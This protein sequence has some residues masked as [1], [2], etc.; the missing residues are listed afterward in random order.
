MDKLMP[1]IRPVIFAVFGT[2][3]L[4]QDI[5]G[6]IPAY[7]VFIGCIIY[8]VTRAYFIYKKRNDVG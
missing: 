8:A 5:N 4:V 1:Y 2:V 7:A 3:I 6:F